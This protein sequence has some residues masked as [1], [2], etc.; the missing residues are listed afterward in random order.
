MVLAKLN[1]IPRRRKVW[2]K[3]EESAVLKAFADH[4]KGTSLPGKVECLAAKKNYTVLKARTWRNLKDKVR[5]FCLEIERQ[6]AKGNLVRR[7][8]RKGSS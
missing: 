2:S 1:D 7:Y 5:N 8:L 4:F 3:E 6:T